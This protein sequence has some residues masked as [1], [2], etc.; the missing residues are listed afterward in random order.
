ML[1]KVWR[2]RWCSIRGPRFEYFEDHTKRKCLGTVPLELATWELANATSM[3]TVRTLGRD[4]KSG[5]KSGRAFYFRFLGDSD[6]TGFFNALHRAAYLRH[7]EMLL[8]ACRTGDAFGVHQVG[9]WDKESLVFWSFV[10]SSE[11]DAC[12]R[13][14]L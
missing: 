7:R 1:N 11:F 13:A 12:G 2:P 5:E 8:E 9:V 4:D 6:R 10:I 3:L 14:L